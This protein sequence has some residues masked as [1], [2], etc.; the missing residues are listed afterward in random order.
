MNDSFSLILK[1]LDLKDKFMVSLDVCNLFTNISQDEAI[2]QSI[3]LI[4]QNNIFQ[5]IARSDVKKLF[6]I[7]TLRTHFLF[8][9]A[10]YDQM[11]GV[12][13]IG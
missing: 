8:N 2:E 12:T 4:I 7:A 5:N 9:G 10:F 13:S 1:S 11:D 3:Y 6:T